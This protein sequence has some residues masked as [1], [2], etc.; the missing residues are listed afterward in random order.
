MHSD[1]T[2][3]IGLGTFSVRLQ[4]NRRLCEA[5]CTPQEQLKELAISCCSGQVSTRRVFTAFGKPTTTDDPRVL[6]HLL[7]IAVPSW[8]IIRCQRGVACPKK[9]CD[10][11]IC[12]LGLFRGARGPVIVQCWCAGLPSA[13]VWAVDPAALW[14]PDRHDDM[15]V[16]DESIGETSDLKS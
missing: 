7:F 3:R 14:N 6:P 12:L 4:Y 1:R 5:I 8:I 15:T 9:T 2:G 16:L 11:I 10:P 13:N